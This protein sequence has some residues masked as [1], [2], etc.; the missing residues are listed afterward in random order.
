M[1]LWSI[2]IVRI[3][4]NEN[5]KTKTGKTQMVTIYNKQTEKTLAKSG[6]IIKKSLSVK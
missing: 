4:K 2:K 5:G 6:V 3:L 1:K